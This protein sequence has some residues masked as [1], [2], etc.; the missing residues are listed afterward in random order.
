MKR[1]Q[2]A[3]FA[4]IILT[5]SVI[6]AQEDNGSYTIGFIGYFFDITAVTS[7]LNSLGYIE[8]E[9]IVYRF[10]FVDGW[11]TIPQEEFFAAYQQATQAIATSPDIDVF[12]TNTDTDAVNLLPLMHDPSTPIVFA[13]SDDPVATGAVADLVAPGGNITGNITNRP[14]ERRLQILTELKPDTDKVYYLYSVTTLEAETVLEQVQAIAES[15]DVEVIPAPIM[16][17]PSALDAI[18]TIPE[19]V[20]WLFLTPYVPY[21]VQFTSVLIAKSLEYKAGIA[22]VINL[23]M[24]GY[25]VG[26]GPDLSL[27]DRQ[28][29][30]TVDRIL[31]GA[32]PAE[33]PV[34]ISE[35]LLTINLEAAQAIEL[36]IPA[37]S[38]RQANLIVRAGDFDET[39]TYIGDGQ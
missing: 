5:T 31:R 8:G 1:I 27:G 34:Q 11:G 39:G 20:D 21:D 33:L 9:N 12:I 32:D 26:Y 35:N 18:A 4:L 13:R 30:R 2:L 16:D 25:V 36:E 23:P 15:L 10:P 22:G 24:Q 29:A 6:Y 3:L 19:G 28:A 38:L 37:A 14:H 7:E 17:V